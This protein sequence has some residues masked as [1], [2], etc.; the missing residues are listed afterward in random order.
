MPDELRIKSFLVVEIHLKWENDQHLVDNAAHLFDAGFV[1]CPHLR[2]D[3][4]HYLRAALLRRPGEPKVE[5]RVVDQQDDL[6]LAVSQHCRER[7][8]DRLNDG[9]MLQHFRETHEAQFID[10]IDELHPLLSHLVST[11]TEDFE[12]GIES[13][14]LAHDARAVKVT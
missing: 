8:L 2:T 9:E 13:L 6:G 14:Q 4:V 5:S 12:P 1:P 3:V 10:V 11:N 7:S